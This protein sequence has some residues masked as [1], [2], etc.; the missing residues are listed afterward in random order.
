MSDDMIVKKCAGSGTS[1]ILFSCHRTDYESYFEILKQDIL[2]IRDCSIY[3]F[4]DVDYYPEDMD[5]Y[6]AII[7]QFDLIIIPISFNF[8]IDESRAKNIDFHYALEHKKPLLPIL[9]EPDLY[10]S[11][12]QIAS[13]QVLDRTTKDETQEPYKGKLKKY[14]DSVLVDDETAQKVRDAFDAYIFLSY[15]KKDR[16]YAQKAM[17]LIHKNDFMRDIAIWYDEYLTPGEDFN[18]EISKNLVKSK[19]MAMLVTPNLNER[20]GGKGNYVIEEEYPAAAKADKPIIPLEAVET[21]RKKLRENFKGISEP[22]DMNNNEQLAKA[23]QQLFIKEG[24]KENNDPTHLY[25]IGLAYLYGIDVEINIQKGIDLLDRSSSSGCAV[26]AAFLSRFYQEN[27]YYLDYGKALNYA[28]IAFDVTKSQYEKTCAPEDIK[29]Y[30]SAVETLTDLLRFIIESKT[31]IDRVTNNKW[32]IKNDISAEEQNSLYG[33]IEKINSE[34]LAELQKVTNNKEELMSFMYH[35][36][37]TEQFAYDE[38]FIEQINSIDN[39]FVSDET[40][41]YFDFA[42]EIAPDHDFELFI[43]QEEQ[44][45]NKSLYMTAIKKAK[46][47]SEEKYFE[48]LVKAWDFF[49][50]HYIFDTLLESDVLEEMCQLE[51]MTLFRLNPVFT[52]NNICEHGW[53][54]DSE[55]CY[56]EI[57]LISTEIQQNINDYINDD[58]VYTGALIE[59]FDKRRERKTAKT[60]LDEFINRKTERGKVAVSDLMRLVLKWDSQVPFYETILDLVLQKYKDSKKEDLSI[61]VEYI[62][63]TYRSEEVKVPE[64]LAKCHNVLNA[65]LDH[66]C[67]DDFMAKYNKMFYVAERI[68]KNYSLYLLEIIAEGYRGLIGEQGKTMIVKEKYQAIKHQLLS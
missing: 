6:Y 42:L 43:I 63:K 7:D 55:F 29:A 1:K 4:N 5:D 20:Y 18:D 13:V 34:Y 30:G 15:R 36:F 52:I 65:Y 38:E 9:V 19:A 32:E 57:N 49:D 8:I 25:F 2:E 14:I 12:N 17:S 16:S 62:I 22:I 46:L 53:Y 54:L 21:D 48:T 44:D 10:E 50:S 33:R 40:D 3:S 60:V 45:L 66:Y 11:F 59:F 31:G 47:I 41:A 67:E 56:N 51:I 68:P 58:P 37:K 39:A 64:T 35:R 27:E 61:F 24:I 28:E 26:S 23:L